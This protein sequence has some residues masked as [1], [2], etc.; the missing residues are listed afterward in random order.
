MTQEQHYLTRFFEPKSVAVIGATETE[1]TVGCV[2]FRN[3][4]AAG[5][6][7]RFIAEEVTGAERDRLWSLAKQFIAAYG[8]YELTAGDREIPIVALSP[9]G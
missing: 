2:L 7:G 5:Y 4:I 9:A 8:D 6:Q 3:I 1:G